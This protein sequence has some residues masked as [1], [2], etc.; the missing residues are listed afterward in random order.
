MLGEDDDAGVGGFG[1]ASGGPLGREARVQLES[2]GE[3]DD[4]GAKDYVCWEVL[5][6]GVGGLSHV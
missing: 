2:G 1:G 4:A 5:G 6:W 3:P